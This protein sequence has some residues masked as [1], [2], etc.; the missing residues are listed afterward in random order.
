[1]FCSSLPIIGF[2]PF[3]ELDP[4]ISKEIYFKF[5][6]IYTN[7][8]SV[9]LKIYEGVQH[10]PKYYSKLSKGVKWRNWVCDW[11]RKSETLFLIRSC[12]EENKELFRTRERPTSPHSRMERVRWERSVTRTQEWNKSG[13]HWLSTLLVFTPP[14]YCSHQAHGRKRSRIVSDSLPTLSTYTFTTYATNW[15]PLP[16]PLLGF[17]I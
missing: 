8:F 15:I 3:K 14:T 13:S 6:F 16:P 4:S 7:F 5:Q 11:S 1:M 9:L 10:F 12:F 17:F 2:C